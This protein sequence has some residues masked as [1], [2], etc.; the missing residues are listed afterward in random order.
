MPTNEEDK[1]EPLGGNKVFLSKAFLVEVEK[2][3]YGLFRSVMIETPAGVRE[4]VKDV[5]PI[6]I[7]REIEGQEQP[8]METFHPTEKRLMKLRS[9]TKAKGIK[10]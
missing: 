8:D 7:L 5:G 9:L 6:D 3:T 1:K 2:K 10:T 4:K